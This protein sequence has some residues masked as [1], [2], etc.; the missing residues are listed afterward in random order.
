MNQLD[1][2]FSIFIPFEISKAE[3]GVDKYQ[4][5][6]IKGTFSTTKYGP[7][8]DGET[9][10][11]AG[12][13]FSD[14]LTS[15][16]LN[17]H[18]AWT[19]DPMA[20]VG[21]PIKVELRNGEP[22]VEGK[23]YSESEKARGIYDL[24]QILE[25]SGSNRRLGF[26]LEGKAL[27]RDKKNKNRV[28]KSKITGLAITPSPK[29]KGTAMELLKGDV[30][31]WM[32]EDANG[33][34]FED[35]TY[36]VDVIGEDGIRRTVDKDFNIK[37]WPLEKSVTTATI[38]PGTPESVE[39]DKKKIRVT[40]DAW[41]DHNK[42]NLVKNLEKAEL[43]IN[44]L[45][46]GY[47]VE[48]CKQLTLLSEAI[49]RG[50]IE[51]DL[52]KAENQDLEKGGKRAVVGEIRNFG[53]RDYIRA[54][55][56]WKYHGKGGGAK[57]TATTKPLFDRGEKFFNEQVAHHIK[58]RDIHQEIANHI[59]SKHGSDA[60]AAKSHIED[61]VKR[62]NEHLKRLDR[63][64]SGEGLLSLNHLKVGDRFMATSDGY[65]KEGEQ[66]PIKIT[67]VS[68]EGITYMTQDGSKTFID[69]N[70]GSMS[71]YI[72]HTHD[73]SKWKPIDPNTKPA[74]EYENMS[75][76]KL[77]ETLKI[78]DVS[79]THY[80]GKR[81]TIYNK[82]TQSLSNSEGII[83]QIKS[84]VIKN[85]KPSDVTYQTIDTSKNNPD[86]EHALYA[87]HEYSYTKGTSVTLHWGDKKVTVF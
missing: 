19:K 38:A 86:I 70:T 81:S 26:S 85:G 75:A 14:L 54:V 23:L 60:V 1:D 17:W 10:E 79:K 56:G 22:Y 68:P 37:V 2:K 67:E 87:E 66:V 41:P 62:H 34:Q 42:D 27:L 16:H 46:E 29:C 33:G 3:D 65:K 5:M 84:L 43:Y 74:N 15:G 45:T 73:F 6:K 76:S 24:A 18:H 12:M 28:L 83:Q 36:L 71:G 82:E 80:E 4:D 47:T 77:L 51:Y 21:E 30:S 25:K 50:E 48:E 49:D 35:T 58:Q 57:E 59:A 31:D 55:D 20:I 39:H 40:A 44:L 32:F 53:G 11:P 7:D 61:I 69:K 64:K 8:S 13:D 72:T 9:L 52:E 78:R 63:I